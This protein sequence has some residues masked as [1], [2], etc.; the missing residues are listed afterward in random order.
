VSAT[1]SPKQLPAFLTELAAWVDGAAVAVE[2]VSYGPHPDQEIDVRTP[3]GSGP[4]PVAVVIH[5]GFWQPGFTRANTAALATALTLG[6]WLTANVEYRRLGP[7]RYRE[8]LADVATAA[9]DLDPDV[10]VGHSSGGQLALWLAARGAAGAAVTLGGVCDLEAAA[11]AGLGGGAVRTFLCGGPDDAPAAYAEADPSRLLPLGAR[12]LLVH[13]VD[14]D[15]VPIEHVRAYAE[16]A[17][18]AG[19]DCRLLELEGADH[20]DVIDPRYPGFGTILEEIPR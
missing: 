13:G 3:P 15:R 20:F 14:D 12:Q 1:R 16:R 6:G 5:G 19:D 4:H 9:R 7:G 10:A 2:T 17:V 18:N 8:L 11:A